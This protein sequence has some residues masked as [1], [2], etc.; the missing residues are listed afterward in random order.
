MIIRNVKVNMH[1]Q[2]NACV[3]KHNFKYVVQPFVLLGQKSCTEHSRPYHFMLA[4]RSLRRRKQSL[5][6][7]LHTERAYAYER[8][9]NDGE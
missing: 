2:A 7:A 4:R 1:L 3:L 8:D 6:R 5:L 9:S